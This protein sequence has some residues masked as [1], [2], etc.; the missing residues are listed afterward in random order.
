MRSG[1]GGEKLKRG[2]IVDCKIVYSIQWDVFAREGSKVPQFYF[3]MKDWECLPLVFY[4]LL[5]GLRAGKNAASE[6]GWLGLKGCCAYVCSIMQTV[7][8]QKR[9]GM[10][11][12]NVSFLRKMVVPLFITPFFQSCGVAYRFCNCSP[13]EVLPVVGGLNPYRTAEN[14][15]DKQ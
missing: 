1:T 2:R 4:D 13:R 11:W 3:M 5:G 6:G 15:N 9:R 8:P 10:I 7:S 14:S 12:Q